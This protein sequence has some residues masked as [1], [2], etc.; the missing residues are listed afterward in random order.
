MAL[1]AMPIMDAPPRGGTAPYGGYERRILHFFWVFD[2]HK[3][4]QSMDHARIHEA[5]A[6]SAG[7]QHY[8]FLQCHLIGKERKHVR[9]ILYGVG[10][11]IVESAVID[12]G[13]YRQSAEL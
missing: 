8:L 7:H 1:P 13:I 6:H 2:R 11:Y 10:S 3:A 9:I 5:Y 12:D 4:G